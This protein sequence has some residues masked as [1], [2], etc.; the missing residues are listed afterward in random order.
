LLVEQDGIVF[1]K[2]EIVLLH[3]HSKTKRNKLEETQSIMYYVKTY[4]PFSTI[5]GFS[6]PARTAS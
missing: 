6:V 4:G 2:L 1:I 5:F 3:L